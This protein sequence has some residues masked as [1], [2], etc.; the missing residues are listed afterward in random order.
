M[1]ITDDDLKSLRERND[2][3]AKAAIEAMGSKWVFH[4]DNSPKRVKKKKTK[5]F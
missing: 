3:R 5:A 4:K 1:F 2:L